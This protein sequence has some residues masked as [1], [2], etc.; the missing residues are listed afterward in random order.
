MTLG[1]TGN[2]KDMFTLFVLGMIMSSLMATPAIVAAGY[3]SAWR[4]TLNPGKRR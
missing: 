1:G 4:R 3:A 2:I